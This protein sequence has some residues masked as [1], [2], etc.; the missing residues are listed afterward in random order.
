M[1]EFSLFRI[2]QP[3][4]IAEVIDDEAIIVNLDS[5]AYYSLRDSACK[6]WELLV[7]QMTA[8]DVALWMAERYSGSPDAIREGVE[9]LLVQLLEEELLV[10][11]DVPASSAPPPAAAQP[12]SERPVFQPPVLEKFTDMADLLLLDPIH[13][14]DVTGWP[15]AA[16]PQ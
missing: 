2:N 13:D 5:G 6:I 7:Q 4:V 3:A 8:A 15:H 12:A 9:T 14:V 10:P 16:Q 11:A 1:T